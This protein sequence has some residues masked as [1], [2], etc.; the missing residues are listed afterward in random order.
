MTNQYEYYR[1]FVL[2]MLASLLKHLI[3]TDKKD[4]IYSV[5]FNIN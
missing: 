4:A 1:R 3:T 5:H 2:Q